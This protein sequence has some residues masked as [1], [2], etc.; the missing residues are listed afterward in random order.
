[1]SDA[2]RAF[3]TPE[4]QAFFWQNG[5]KN[6]LLVHGFPGTPAEMRPL[7]NRL[8]QTGW[9]TK[10]ILLPGFGP[11]IAD[12][13]RYNHADWLALVI[14]QATALRRQGSLLLIGNSMGAALCLAAASHVVP[15]GLLLFAPFWRLKNQLINALLPLARWISRDFHPFKRT[16]FANPEVRH[17]LKRTIPDADLD[18]PAVQAAIRTLSIPTSTLND[19]MVT[20]KMG[21]RAAA[22]VKAPV[23]VIQ[24]IADETATLAMTRKLCSR[25]KNLDGLTELPAGHDL[26]RLEGAPGDEAARAALTFAA[27]ISSAAASGETGRGSNSACL[28]TS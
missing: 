27:R 8:H 14:E 25:L 17:N 20:G 16:D 11:A 15:D 1:M 7:A 18:D 5:P 12:M 24:G 26:V 6:A 19:V 2:L 10:A 28:P 9:G 21:Y 3:H 23:K 22:T 13:G 4:H